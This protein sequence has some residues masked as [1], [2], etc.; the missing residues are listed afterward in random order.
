[1]RRVSRDSVLG[2]RRCGV[3]RARG[4][5]HHPPQDDPAASSA[6]APNTTPV[7]FADTLSCH[8]PTPS[9]TAPTMASV[10]AARRT[11]RRARARRTRRIRTHRRNLPATFLCRESALQTFSLGVPLRRLELRVVFAAAALDLGLVILCAQA[12]LFGLEPPHE[13]LMLC[14]FATRSSTRTSP[15]V[16]LDSRARARP[17]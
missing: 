17:G 2:G 1:M 11:R 3:V 10:V 4:D 16:S 14:C 6:T 15:G 13:P 9:A 12:I 7:H 8:A 5:G